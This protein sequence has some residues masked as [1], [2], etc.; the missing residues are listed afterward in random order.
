MRIGAYSSAL[1]G[2]QQATE[3]FDGAASRI[4]RDGVEGDLAGNFV[5][6]NVAKASVKANC[7][8]VRTA[9]EMLGTLLDAVV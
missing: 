3:R 5:T 8:V 4:A 7:A 9:D 2:I 1:A 6:M